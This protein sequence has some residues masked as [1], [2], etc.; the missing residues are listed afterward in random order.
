MAVTVGGIQIN[1]GV[2][3]QGVQAGAN[4]VQRG[5]VRIVNNITN[6]EKAADSSVGKIEAMAGALTTLGAAL[7]ANFAI[8][9][10]REFTILAARVENLG[11]ILENVGAIAGKNSG[12]L[13]EL[14]QRVKKLGI[15]TQ[16]AR[17]GLTLLAQSELDLNNGARLA[18]IAQDAAVIAGINSSEAYERLLTAVQRGNSVMLRNLGIIVNLNQLY[19]DYA[20]SV[21]RTVTSLT[22]LEKRQ[23]LI[24]EVFRKGQLIAGTYEAS[25]NDVY[26]QYTSLERFTEEA[27]RAI[28][29]SFLPVM[30]K[31]VRASTAFAK[32][33]AD[34]PDRANFVA[35]ILAAAAAVSTLTAGLGIVVGAFAGLTALL[36]NPFTAAAGAAVIAVGAL[37]GQLVAASGAAEQAEQSLNDVF[38]GAEGAA[39]TNF[40]IDD[41]V[42]GLRTLAKTAD[43][44]KTA[45][46]IEKVRS[47]I[48]AITELSPELGRSLSYAFK[49]GSADAGTLD[50]ELSKATAS[51]QAFGSTAKDVAVLQG[52]V[53]KRLDKLAQIVSY[54]TNRSFKEVR[55]E[56]EGIINAGGDLNEVIGKV[57]GL[58]KT[59]GATAAGINEA[60]T[61]AFNIAEKTYNLVKNVT[62]LNDPNKAAK[63]LAQAVSE[64]AEAYG[65]AVAAQK[66]FGESTQALGEELNTLL[67]RIRAINTYRREFGFDELNAQVKATAQQAVQANAILK[68]VQTERRKIFKDTN[69][70]ILDDFREF[71][72]KQS[73]ELR[74]QRN[75]IQK[76][77]D[78]EAAIAIARSEDQQRAAEEAIRASGKQGAAL[79]AAI[80]E[81]I[82]K[83]KQQRAAI[84]DAIPERVAQIVKDLDDAERALAG[85]LELA[86]LQLEQQA[87]QIRIL[88]D[89]VIALEDN[90]S[91]EMI[92][93]QR[94]FQREMAT[95]VAALKELQKQEDE[96]R[97]ELSSASVGTPLYEK[98]AE[99]IKLIGRLR[100]QELDKIKLKEREVT[101]LV[102][103]ER[104]S[105]FEKLSR[106]EL[107]LLGKIATLRGTTSLKVIE[108]VQA[109]AD[110]QKNARREVDK[111]I[112]AQTLD[113]IDPSG[114]TAAFIGLVDQFKQSIERARGDQ[115]DIIR[116]LFPEASRKILADVDKS[117]ART[118]RQLRRF[119]ED[120]TQREA[121][122]NRAF[123][124]RVEEQ[125][126][127]GTSYEAA[128]ARAELEKQR[129]IED[130]LEQR[131][132]L[133]KRN[134]E[135]IAAKEFI[136][137]LAKKGV[138][139]IETVIKT[140]GDL[141]S[142]EE[143]QGLSEA[144]IQENLKKLKAEQL[145]I[146]E[147]ELK[148]TQQ[149]LAELEKVDDRL[150][151]ILDK[152]ARQTTTFDAT[153]AKEGFR[154]PAAR[155]GPIERPQA[156][157]PVAQ[158]VSPEDATFADV[159]AFRAANPNAPVPQPGARRGIAPG[160]NRGPQ[161]PITEQAENV[162]QALEEYVHGGGRVGEQTIGI[163][164]DIATNLEEAGLR[165]AQIAE[166]LQEVRGFMKRNVE[167]YKTA[168]GASFRSR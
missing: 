70:Q 78:Q 120:A 160:G 136:A 106:A 69:V 92:R 18:R 99:G 59:T 131:Q 126:K 155:L 140:R 123:K 50:K 51:F 89:S 95:S 42:I 12:E 94:K 156:P 129:G 148:V 143:Q 130:E 122:R 100:E 21:G 73:N 60:T 108:Q 15:T 102:Y 157:V 6:I 56:F 41:L 114:K 71:I 38:K 154:K 80:E 128:V 55:Q 46:D 10:A 47:R 161:T 166:A 133:E 66:D 105:Q 113:V 167:A 134:K 85:S 67:G 110:A 86:N 48:A 75:Q 81:N 146:A 9:K 39:A 109:L 83:F 118:A 132:E 93:I 33:L 24:N 101:R 97:K 119:N 32:S 52:E 16:Q 27:Q 61:Q 57:A 65:D 45:T 107:D 11:T 152:N 28:G 13:Y 30:E 23:V 29:N 103:N 79:N 54:Q 68:Q 72:A 91:G 115:L 64:G 7:G 144:S 17:H 127:Q 5:A 149:Q 116:K 151:S 84:R 25:L 1:V 36:A 14:E 43:I 141:L 4:Q 62:T 153:A 22:P 26:K 138:A 163:F 165:D 124:E 31:I 53:G 77:A 76:F 162:R 3:A 150:N 147:Q 34:N 98:L 112:Q 117:L 88:E 2:N 125:V 35:S 37:A 137:Q 40:K 139:D 90:L 168:F 8:D 142:L 111:F 20:V 49:K 159:R 19:Q 145:A 104:K 82:Q 121:D 87:E 96:L 164:K 63:E 74:I 44:T 135:E 58:A 158:Q